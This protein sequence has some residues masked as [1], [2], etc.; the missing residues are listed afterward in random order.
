MVSYGIQ[1]IRH[2]GLR[3][4]CFRLIYAV[5]LRL[6]MLRRRTPAVP[7]HDVPLS[8]WLND[9]SL[10]RPFAYATFRRR[11]SAPSFF[12]PDAPFWSTARF[13]NWDSATEGLFEPVERAEAIMGGTLDY[14]EMQPCHVGF[15][16]VW[17]INPFSNTRWTDAIMR[18]HWSQIGDFDQ[19]DIKL[20]WEP[21]RFSFA[22]T[23]ARAYARM[24]TPH[25]ERFAQAFWVAFEDWVEHNPPNLGPN[26]RCGQETTFR[27]MAWCF[28]MHVFADA[29]ASTPERLTRLAQ[30]IAVSGTRIAANL[31]YALSQNNN[32]GISEALG[33]WTIGT[34]FPEFRHA[35]RWRADG[36]KWLEAQ[37][38]TLIYDDGAFSQHS[39]NYHRLMLHDFAWAIALDAL[40][41]RELSQEL[42][43]RVGDAAD[44]LHA[45]IEPENGRVPRFGAN[46]SALVLPLTN[47]AP[48]DFRPVVQTL[49]MLLRGTRVFPPG[50]WDEEMFWLGCAPTY[51]PVDQVFSTPPNLR[52]KG[53]GY[54][55]LRGNSSKVFTHCPERFHHRP[56][57]ADLLHVDVWWRGINVAQ[58]AG[59]YSYNPSPLMRAG[60]EQT[61]FHNTVSIDGRDQ[62]TRVGRFLWLPWAQ[63][64]VIQSHVDQHGRLT[65]WSAEHNGYQRLSSPVRHQRTVKLEQPVGEDAWWVTDDLR[66]MLKHTYTLHWLLVNLPHDFRV[67]S[68][69][70]AEVCLHTPRG[71]LKI[72]VQ[73]SVPATFT[74]DCATADGLFGW[75][76]PHYNVLQPALALRAVATTSDVRFSTHFEPIV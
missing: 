69:N 68:P 46:D 28:S 34:L 73:S 9:K 76:A 21:S 51:G 53:G 72:A 43:Q 70:Q 18:Q 24:P 37:A 63:G 23:L 15:P 13:V 62:M 48:D 59:T 74:L 22:Y 3:W 61:A 35:S 52:G 16:P 31:P 17:H 67:T 19:G 44:W 2:L 40:N 38:G 27:V 1:L 60:L 36:L 10:A 29:A 4:V 57:H 20:I 39:M 30:A 71:R 47:C 12:A 26:W 45:L 55:V 32:H 42:R 58:D 75:Y 25:G 11:A 5:Q 7:W 33:L 64:R 50:A 49:N 66:G 56:S 41:H 14:F 65:M 8:H 6:G 54:F